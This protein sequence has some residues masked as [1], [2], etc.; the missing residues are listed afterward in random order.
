MVERQRLSPHDKIFFFWNIYYNLFVIYLIFIMNV[1]Y[2]D[3]EQC[4]NDF[5]RKLSNAEVVYYSLSTLIKVLYLVDGRVDGMVRI[6]NNW[7]V[8]CVTFLYNGGIHV[9]EFINMYGYKDCLNKPNRE[10]FIFF[11]VK[12]ILLFVAMALGATIIIFYYIGACSRN[13]N[14]ERGGGNLIN[15][16]HLNTYT[17][18]NSIIIDAEHQQIVRL[19]ETT[20]SICLEDFVEGEEIRISKCGHYFKKECADRWFQENF[21]CPICRKNP[22]SGEQA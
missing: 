22:L 9:A 2:N 13:R 8:V 11:F 18:D 20:C 21:S 19:E 7:L 4:N 16:V 15:Q 1:S 10:L 12:I 3:K 5:L 17:K 6:R 14:R